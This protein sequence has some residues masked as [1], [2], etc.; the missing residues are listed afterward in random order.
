MSGVGDSEPRRRPGGRSARVRAAVLGATLDELAA[1]GYGHLGFEEI[2]RRAGVH[3]TTIY[4]NWPTREAL[5]REALLARSEVTVPVPDTGSLRT[6]LVE[7]A[8]AI[9]ANITA[10]EYEA[11]VRAVASETRTE[12]ALGQ[13]AKE[14]WQERLRLLRVIVLRGIERGELPGNVDP[15]VL[16]EMLLGPLYLRLLITREPLDGAFLELLVDQLIGRSL[17]PARSAR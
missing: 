15:N 1:V 17:T 7:F 2:A 16:L 13:A 3:K 12:G 11:I 6:D 5:V 14:F 10:P 8:R 4:R 9:V